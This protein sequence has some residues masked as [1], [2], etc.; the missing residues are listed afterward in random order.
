MKAKFYWSYPVR[1]LAR[2]GQRTGLSVFCIAVGVLAVVALQLVGNMVNVGLTGDVRALNGGD[3]AVF[4]YNSPLSASDLATFDHLKAQGVL[5]DYTAAAQVNSEADDSQGVTHALAVWAVNPAKFPLAGAPQFVTPENGTLA[6]LLSGTDV[7]VTESLLTDLNVRM[8]DALTIHAPG[9]AFTVTIKGV[10]KN[11]ALFAGS[12]ILID[13]QSFAALPGTDQTPL[14][15][16]VVYADVPGDTDANAAAAKQQIQRALP[17]TTITTTKDALQTNEASVQQIRYLLQVVGLLALLIGGIGIINTMQVL[18]R[19]RQIEIA[20]LKTAGYHRWELY[21]LFGVEAG[22]LGLFGGIVGSAAGV[23][24]SFLIKG[25]IEHMLALS[26]PDAVDP[27]TVLS[28]VAVGFFTAL[29]FGLLPIVQTSQIRPIAVLRNL[30]EHE[31][32]SLWLSLLLGLLLVALFF[33]LALSILKNTLVSLGAVGGGG[34]SLLL[35]S[36]GFMLVALV[37]GKLPV[38]GHF[39]WGSGLLCAA[40]LAISTLLTVALP[41]FGLLCLALTLLFVLVVFA[42]RAWKVLVKI[43]L[44][45]IGRKKARTSSTL[46]ALFVGIFAIGLVLTLSQSIHAAIKGLQASTASYNAF[47]QVSSSDKDTVD[48]ELAT[49]SGIKQQTIYA[50]APSIPRQI[51]GV[52]LAQLLNGQGLS[53]QAAADLSGV[54]GYH[55]AAAQLPTQALAQGSHDRKPGRRLTQSD[56]G[57]NRVMIPQALSQAPLNL[58]L[59]DHI[60]LVGPDGSTMA[61]VTVVGFYTPS[62]LTVDPPIL[63]DMSLANTLTGGHPSYLYSLILDPN[64]IDQILRQIQQAVPSVGVVNLVEIVNFIQS[65]L[66]NLAILVMT[67]S[68]LAMLAGFIIIA[69]AVALSTLERRRELG[70]LKAVGYTSRTI[71]GEVL[72]ENGVIGFAGSVLAMLLATLLAL[73]LGK[74]VFN[75][76]VQANA[77]LVL[78]IV[79]A[80]AVTCMGI[81]ALVAWSATRVRP[82]EVLR[83]E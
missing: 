57:S 26:L 66:N 45:N 60:T 70:I 72:F 65:L 11:T 25:L 24:V 9:R 41:A 5:T 69:N 17:L 62:S 29:I 44:R 8:G 32:R 81:A 47:L 13:L 28:G 56:A 46:V 6:S 75:V 20:M 61:T 35:L 71:L 54:T 27:I 73:V 12:T 36:L 3:L 30:G 2:G 51:N 19:R 50:T 76:T 77:G 4:S 23:G 53:Q 63:G 40:E 10:I 83:Y 43:A 22:L 79:A 34:F 37:I 74:V 42:P 16:R 7:V 67:I 78:G 18:L 1:S 64:R 80:T 68:S 59:G 82:L 38:P 21:L 15:Y 39:S 55:L 31:R 58:K 33:V 48:Q 14:G 52:S 49:I